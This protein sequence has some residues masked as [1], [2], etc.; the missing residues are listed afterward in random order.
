MDLTRHLF[1]SRQ[2]S[3][4]SDGETAQIKNKGRSLELHGTY[5]AFP[6]DFIQ[7]LRRAGMEKTFDV[8]ADS[9]ERHTLRE[10][11]LYFVELGAVRRVH[12]EFT[13]LEGELKANHSFKSTAHQGTII[14]RWL[15]CACNVC[16][17]G[18][19]GMTGSVNSRISIPPASRKQSQ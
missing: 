19:D 4:Y 5:I 16:F 10:R 7:E 17:L 6:K 9:K 12:R 1:L 15:P 11:V 18:H 14:L 13:G 2:G 3:Q 8:P